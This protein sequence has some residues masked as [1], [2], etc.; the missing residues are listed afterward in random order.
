MNFESAA[1][2]HVQ[3]GSARYQCLSENS[4]Q[5]IWVLTRE[6]DQYIY[7]SETKTDYF[8]ASLKTLSSCWGHPLL[9]G[10]LT[11]ECMGNRR[12]CTFLMENRREIAYSAPAR[13]ALFGLNYI[14]EGER[15][16]YTSPIRAGMR[17][18]II[19]YH[20]AAQAEDPFLLSEEEKAVLLRARAGEVPP[21]ERVELYRRTISPENI[22]R[23]MKM[24]DHPTIKNELFQLIEEVIAC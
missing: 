11:G 17:T 23:L 7:D 21:E 10:N 2:L 1:I 6:M 13:T 12:L 5:D 4:D 8:L 14:A 20:M 15:C 9:L 22:N 16:G 3:V 18:A 24:P 19:L